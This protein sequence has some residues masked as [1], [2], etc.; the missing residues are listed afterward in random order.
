MK[1]EPLSLN[2]APLSLAVAAFI[3]EVVPLSLAVAAF[4]LKVA[5]LSL[6]V[7]AFILEVASLSL[8]VAAFILKVAPLSLNDRTF[9]TGDELFIKN[10]CEWNEVKRGDRKI[11]ELLCKAGD[12]NCLAGLDTIPIL[13]NCLPIQ[14]LPPKPNPTFLITNYE[15]IILL[16]LA[17]AKNAPV[18]MH[19]QQ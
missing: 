7:A 5:S 3:L 17:S 1:V 4:I 9:I 8:A 2:V 14:P 19:L 12:D 11:R 13:H 15:R 6:A 10:H 18:L 16:W